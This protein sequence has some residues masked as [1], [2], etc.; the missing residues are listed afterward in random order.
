MA[1]MK[2]H[3]AFA[4]VGSGAFLAV[5]LACNYHWS[6]VPTT[7]Q[8][9]DEPMRLVSAFPAAKAEDG[10]WQ[11]ICLGERPAEGI[12]LHLIFQGTTETGGDNDLG[13]RPGDVV[14]TVGVSEPRDVLGEGKTV[15]A[16]DFQV[17][18]DC[19]ERYPDPDI[20]SNR[21]CQGLSNPGGAT[22]VPPVDF[23][24]VSDLPPARYMGRDPSGGLVGVAIL[25][26]LSGS[27]K[28]FVD[29]VTKADV[30]P[31]A[32]DISSSRE[33]ATDPDFTWI[34][35][36]RNFLRSLNAKDRSIV[37]RFGE[38]TTGAPTK[39]VCFDRDGNTPEQTLRE[40][41]YSADRGLVLDS[42]TVG[43]V[44]QKPELDKLQFYPEG[45]GRSPLWAAV[46]EVY[47]FMKGRT[48]DEVRHIIVLNDGPDTCSRSSPD[49]RP[50]YGKTA[51]GICSN[52]AYESFRD[53]VV[54]DLQDTAKPKIHIHFVQI[55]SAGYLDRD[56]RQQEIACLTGGSYQFINARDPVPFVSTTG[57]VALQ[58]ALTEALMRVRYSLVGVWRMAIALPD[59][60]QPPMRGVIYSI[61][62]TVKMKGRSNSL[63]GIDQFLYLMVGDASNQRLASLDRRAAVRIPCS[64]PSDCG[65][66]NEPVPDC[67]EQACL[68]T[69]KICGFAAVADEQHCGTNGICCNGWCTEGITQCAW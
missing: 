22:N 30:H 24:Y 29:P 62:G 67:R 13:I 35:A 65:W 20:G 34:A 36:V 32:Q 61:K 6:L 37:F 47:E 57:S 51:M 1:K 53:K 19:I 8:L 21:D 52:V 63:S 39:V 56:M 33:N 17:T 58:D 5:V 23:R 10:S 55:Q 31:Q 2:R 4:T 42:H 16:D 44:L 46:D 68:N 69:D 7:F 48:G 14:A 41:C 12:L 60:A 28:G 25:V 11:P 15:I 49:F 27:I 43:N 54:A 50:F 26:D 59:L 66:L 9:G 64:G 3:I 40:R 38:S 18:I 45:P